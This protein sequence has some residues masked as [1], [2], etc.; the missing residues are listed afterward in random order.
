MKTLRAHQEEVHQARRLAKASIYSRIACP[1][2]GLEMTGDRNEILASNPPCT[3]LTCP[4]KHRTTATLP[5]DWQP[6]PELC[7]HR[8]PVGDCSIC[9]NTLR[10]SGE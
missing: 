1:E 5:I 8:A 9:V 10:G 3:W 2:C 6:E 7:A 4:N